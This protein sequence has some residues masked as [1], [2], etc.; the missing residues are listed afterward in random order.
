ML[1]NVIRLASIWY[2]GIVTVVAHTIYADVM[3]V[4]ENTP[5]V[6]I[7]YNFNNFFSIPNNNELA[8]KY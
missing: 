7:F 3:T 4:T 1:L 2:N 8:F 5:I 6:K